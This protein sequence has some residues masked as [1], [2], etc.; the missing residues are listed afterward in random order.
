M[1]GVRRAL[2]DD[3]EGHGRERARELSSDGGVHGTTD[4]HGRAGGLAT[5]GAVGLDVD[6]RR[7]S[8]RAA[9]R[10]GA[11]GE[12]RRA[13]ANDEGRGDGHEPRGAKCGDAKATLARPRTRSGRVARSRVDGR[14]KRE[15]VDV[16]FQAR[17]S[18]VGVVFQARRSIARA[19]VV[20]YERTKARV[21]A[22]TEAVKP[23][24]TSSPSRRASDR[25]GSKS[26]CRRF[27]CTSSRFASPSGES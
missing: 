8:T 10:A 24:C 16:V 19:M 23:S 15:G 12:G 14:G 4:V 9:R 1:P 7:R 21:R 27:A 18:G 11:A 6:D 2:V 26:R 5:R 13:R 3:D 22:S 20:A 25:D 17:R